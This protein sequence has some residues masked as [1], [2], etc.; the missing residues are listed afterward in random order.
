[1]LWHRQFNNLKYSPQLTNPTIK[2]LG[3]TRSD[4]FRKLVIDNNNNIYAVGYSYGDYDGNTNSDPTKKSA[5]II[6]Q[7]FDQNLNLLA[8]K[9]FGS[10][11]EDRGY[12]YLKDTILFI[13][14]M[15][16]GAIKTTSNGSFDGFLLALNTLDL[17]FNTNPVL[18]IA[19][20]EFTEIINIIR[21]QRME[22][23]NLIFII[24]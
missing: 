2:Q 22:L 23:F 24:Q 4:L 1:M 12:C 19:D 17:S 11:H 20:T 21:I 3:T 16:E 10:P 7:K 9:Q 18:S 5:D 13:G 15:T 14:G 6:V 8:S